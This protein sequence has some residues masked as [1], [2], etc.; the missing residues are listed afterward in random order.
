MSD[1]TTTTEPRAGFAAAAGDDGGSDEG[2]NDGVPFRLERRQDRVAVLWFDLPNRSVNTLDPSLVAPLREVLADVEGD[3]GVDALVLA[4]AKTDSFVVGADVELLKQ[5]GSEQE[6]RELALEAQDATNAL[7]AFPKPIVAAIHGD[8]LGGGLEIA[9]ACDGRVASSDDVTRLG[10]PEVKLGLLP[11][12]GGTQRLPRLVGLEEALD[13]I[14]AGRRIP[15][16]RA[17]EIGLVDEVVHRSIL[18]EVAAARARSLAAN[19]RRP[20]ASRSRPHSDLKSLLLE[21]NPLGRR[22]LFSQAEKRAREKTGGHMPAPLEALEAIRVG[23]EEGSERGLR[24]EAEA[25]GRLAAS[26]QSAALV[27]LF[28]WRQE[29]SKESGCEDPE[30]APRLVEKVAVVGAGLMGAGIARITAQEAGLPVRLRDVD[31]QPLLSGLRRIADGLAREVERKRLSERE[32][33]RILARIHPTTGAS[34]LRRADVVIEAVVE[35]LEVKRRVLRTVEESVTEDAIFATNT[36][37]L[38]IAQIAEAARRPERVLGMHF[39]SP[40]E[41][42]PLLEVVRGERTSPEAVATCVELGKRQ[43]KTVIVVRDGPGFYTTRILAPYL[44][45]ACRLLGEGAPIEEIDQALTG[46]GFPVGPLRLL[47][48]VG[49]DVGGEIAAVLHEAF[50]ERMAPAPAQSAL[51]GD[52]RRGRKNGRGFYRYVRRGRGWKRS[53][54]VDE[55]V[56]DLLGVEPEEGAVAPARIVDRCVLAMAN[57]AVRCLDEGVV[58]SVRDAEV[59]A[60]FGLGFPPFLGG[61]LRWIDRRGADEVVSGLEVLAASCGARFE[62]AERLVSMARSGRTFHS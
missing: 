54:G 22:L 43:G 19:E 53:D 1:G 28:L 56:Y 21:H 13:L 14:L 46:F 9:L 7:E 29:L 42:V 23:V 38:P 47:D 33:E 2:G 57:E 8:C 52:D 35:D 4:S 37:S 55:E 25:F 59:G 62:P 48:E 10:L 24:F 31:H 11:G 51:V 44:S 12:A 41:R 34:G 30:V 45:E 61:P 36:S 49:I 40:A 15:A 27:D 39:F 20:H 5:V 60:V 17:L 58:S 32:R 26:P 50:G 18:V 6:G 3:P 16:Q